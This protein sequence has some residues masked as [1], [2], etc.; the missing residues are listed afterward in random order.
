MAKHVTLY[1]VKVLADNGSGSWSGVVAGIDWAV[2]HH[3][4]RPA[5]GNMSLGGGAS[6]AVDDAVRRAVADGIVMCVAAGNDYQN[7]ANY[8]PARTPEAITVGATTSTDGFASYSNFGSVVDILA[9]G[10]SIKSAWFTSSTA[11]NTISGTSMATPHV[12]GASALY[13]ET[14]P[15]ST[16]AQV[17]AGLISRATS[18]RIT[19]VPTGTANLLL[20]INFGSVTPPQ[21]PAAPTLNTPSNGAANLALNPTLSWFAST[22][23]SSYGVQVSTSP[24]FSSTI[25]NTSVT[26]TSVGLSGLAQGTTYYWRVNATNTAGASAWSE[27][28][29]FTTTST[30]ALTAP[31][32]SS[33]APDAINLGTAPTLIW[34]AAS[35]AT[36][37]DVQVSTKSNFSILVTNIANLANTSTTLNG[38]KRNTNYYWRVRSR[39]GNTISGWSTIWNFKTAR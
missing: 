21:P 33:P 31:L 10:S 38:L 37:Y 30:L 39:N 35:G 27:T 4:T 2:G 9:P 16:P 8:S 12:A 14:Y 24:D 23:A 28:R 26:T 20:H 15:G 34:N 7:A 13:L 32:L 19:A 1:A 18:N 36:G 29:S 11:T 6:T 22:N 5:V 25:L 17:S 3:T